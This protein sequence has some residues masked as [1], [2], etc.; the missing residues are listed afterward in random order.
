MTAI[1]PKIWNAIIDISPVQ[2]GVY[3]VVKQMQVYSSGLAEKVL[4]Y[5]F[6]ELQE[7]SHDFYKELMNEED[8]QRLEKNLNKLLTAEHDIM[9]EG[10]YRV[11]D[12][13]NNTIWVRSHHRVLDRDVNG[14][15]LKFITST[16]DITELK[17]LE[18]KLEREVGIL[19]AIPPENIEALKIQLNAVNNIMDQ[20]KENHFSS[21]MDRRLWNYMY[22]S[23]K[24][25]NEVMEEI[26]P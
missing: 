15:P 3:D 23:V 20:F 13:D 16:E 9:I 11:R 17:E 24:K 12:K 8:S 5:S 10:I 14:K 25:M 19:Y 4:G 6:E 18:M 26:K 22:F 7:F 21:E 2:F 1:T